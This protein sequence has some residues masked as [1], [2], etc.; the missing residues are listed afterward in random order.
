MRCLVLMV[1]VS[2]VAG[3]AA[4]AA[5][6]CAPADLLLARYNASADE[7]HEPGAVTCK[8]SQL[9]DESLI[10]MRTTVSAK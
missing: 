7:S 4:A 5:T 2:W 10:A 9:Q 1:A 8:H 3:A 6:S